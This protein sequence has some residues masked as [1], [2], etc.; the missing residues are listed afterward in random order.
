[1]SSATPL[2]LFCIYKLCNCRSSS[3]T[4]VAVAVAVHT[5]HSVMCTHTLT[6]LLVRVLSPCPCSLNCLTIASISLSLSSYFSLFPL[7]AWEELP[8]LLLPGGR[9]ECPP[10]VGQVQVEG[11]QPPSLSG[12]ERNGQGQCQEKCCV[13]RA[14]WADWEDLLPAWFHEWGELIRR[15]LDKTKHFQRAISTELE[16]SWKSL[17]SPPKG[18]VYTKRVKFQESWLDIPSPHEASHNNDSS[19][20]QPSGPENFQIM[21]TLCQM[22]PD[23]SEWDLF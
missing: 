8:H 7:Q 22:I 13:C 9:T 19:H 10:T 3:S 11:S 2:H 12:A 4:A 23:Y 15:K 6:C 5:D 17:S 18:V 20:S 14:V 1:M 16:R 21:P